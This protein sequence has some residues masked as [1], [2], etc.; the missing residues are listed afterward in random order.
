MPDEYV[1]G[2]VKDPG[3]PSDDGA[4]GHLT[5]DFAEAEEADK[6]H[7]KVMLEESLAAEQFSSDEEA[8][9][10]HEQQR[11]EFD[12]TLRK[13]KLKYSTALSL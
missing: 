10:P 8:E 7:E 4:L 12:K 13:A 9:K 6:A 3:P 11:L 1:V 2:V 5:K